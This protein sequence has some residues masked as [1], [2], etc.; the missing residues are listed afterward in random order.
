LYSQ[1]ESVAAL[2]MKLALLRKIRSGEICV[3]WGARAD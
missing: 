1:N 3:P 2:A